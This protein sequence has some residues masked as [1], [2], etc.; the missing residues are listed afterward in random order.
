MAARA[1]GALGK[2]GGTEKF[3]EAV[4]DTRV[5]DGGASGKVGERGGGVGEETGGSG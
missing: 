3:V 5:I 2:A 4:D 1:D